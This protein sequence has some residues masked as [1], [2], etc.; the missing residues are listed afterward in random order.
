MHLSFILIETQWPTK[1]CK[2]QIE[3]YHLPLT[4]SIGSGS[5]STRP[6]EPEGHKRNSD[7]KSPEPSSS[8]PERNWNPRIKP[9]PRAPNSIHTDF[10]RLLVE[11]FLDHACKSSSLSLPIVLASIEFAMDAFGSFFQSSNRKGWSYDSLNN[12][13]QISPAV[14]S[15]LKRVRF[16]LP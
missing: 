5:S 1:Q 2:S 7:P 11:Q 3:L 6:R 10:E 9:K 12:F 15:H 4:R 16:S 13:R 8:Y 14:Q